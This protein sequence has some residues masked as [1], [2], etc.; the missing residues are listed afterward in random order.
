MRILFFSLLLS[1]NLIASSQNLV[2]N[3]SFEGYRSLQN[4]VDYYIEH[5]CLDCFFA[6]D[7]QFPTPTTVDYF[8]KKN[9]I[10]NFSVPN[11]SFGY[12][13]AQDGNAYIGIIPMNWDGVGEHLTGTLKQPLEKGKKYNVSFYIRHAGKASRFGFEKIG[14][15]FHERLF[16]LGTYDFPFYKDLIEK[17]H[18]FD[19]VSKNNCFVFNDTAWTKIEGVYTAEGREQFFTMGVFWLGDFYDANKILTMINRKS[20]SLLRENLM[21]QKKYQKLIPMKEEFEPK[22]TM[23]QGDPYYFIDNVSI[24]LMK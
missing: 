22:A 21:Q 18:N 23:P 2:K 20:D 24:I 13:P 7:W 19:I 16:P 12:H 8:N 9:D 1:L 10:L 5:F 4:N 6:N 11:N 17:E 15:H 3:G 14:I